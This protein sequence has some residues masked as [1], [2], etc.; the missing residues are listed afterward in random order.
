MKALSRIKAVTNESSL[1]IEAAQQRAQGSVIMRARDEG[2]DIS[3]ARTGPKKG[4][5]RNF[6]SPAGSFNLDAVGFFK[7]ASRYPRGKK[8]FG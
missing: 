4:E 1:A 7:G 5:R 2:T 8:R 6:R 3:S